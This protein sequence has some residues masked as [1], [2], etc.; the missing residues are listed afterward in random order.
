M[1]F[2][3]HSN[4]TLSTYCIIFWFILLQLSDQ[5]N[6]VYSQLSPSNHVSTK[7]NDLSKQY[8]ELGVQAAQSG[9]FKLSLGYFRSSCRL[10]RT[11]KRFWNDLGVA[12]MRMKDYKKAQSKFLKALKLDPK[13]KLAKKNLK[14]VRSFLLPDQVEQVDKTLVKQKHQLHELSPLD[15]YHKSLHINTSSDPSDHFIPLEH[16]ALLDEPFVI[17]SAD[18]HWGWRIDL[19][20]MDTVIKAHGDQ[21]VDYYPNSMNDRNVHPYRIPFNRAYQQLEGPEDVY[22]DID[23]SDTHTYIHWNMP[24]PD[25][26]NLLISMNIS[27]PQILNDTFWNLECFESPTQSNQFHLSTHWKMLLIGE[28][29]AGMFNHRDYLQSA[30]YQIQLVGNKRWHLCAPS[31]DKYLYTD[32][33][34]DMFHPD[35]EHFPETLKA[36]CFDFILHQGDVLFYPKNYWHQTINL[37]TPTIALTGT[38]VTPTNHNDIRDRLEGQCNGIG[39]LFIPEPVFCAQLQKCFKYWKEYFD[40]SDNDTSSIKSSHMSNIDYTQEL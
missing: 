24:L 12:E 2:L 9:D 11:N 33:D 39:N 25:F 3:R 37:D 14:E 29:G 19:F 23:I 22:H 15:P 26:D 27:L 28:E 17:R 5:N 21:I 10:D 31:Q 16:F 13:Y 35:Y 7:N 40:V 38:L 20:D 34:I 4:K 32:G 1:N 6:N 18:Q 30:S 36:N 8:H